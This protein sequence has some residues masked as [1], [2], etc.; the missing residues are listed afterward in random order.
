MNKKVDRKLEIGGSVVEKNVSESL[1]KLLEEVEKRVNASYKKYGDQY[2]I[3]DI[4]GELDEEIY[5]IVGWPLLLALRLKKISDGIINKMNEE[6]L[7]KFVARA[8]T[9]YLKNL[10][11]KIQ[12]EL[13]KRDELK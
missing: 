13:Q 8:K 11:D 7:G 6:Y 3:A 5:D 9:E 2:L 1:K 10:Y 4:K 12:T